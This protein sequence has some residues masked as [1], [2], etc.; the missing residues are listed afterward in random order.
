MSIS[1]LDTHRFKCGVSIKYTNR[2]LSERTLHALRLNP[3]LPEGQLQSRH[4]RGRDTGLLPKLVRLVGSLDRALN[5]T[6]KPLNRRNG[7]N[8]EP[9]STQ[10]FHSRGR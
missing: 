1:G 5:E 3:A 2:K 7:S 9:Q 8:S 6:S 4:L 10:R